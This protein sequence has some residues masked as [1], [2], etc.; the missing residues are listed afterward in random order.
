MLIRTLMVLVCLMPLSIFGQLNSNQIDISNLT[1]EQKILGE[2]YLK[3]SRINHGGV[4]KSNQSNA[5]VT[6]LNS[7]GNDIQSETTTPETLTP[8][9]LL[10]QEYNAIDIYHQV[11]LKENRINTNNNYI[12]LEQF[13]YDF[14]YEYYHRSNDMT[15]PEGYQLQKGD[16][17]TLF[18]F[19]KKEQI[20][21]LT[22]DNEGEVFIPNIGPIVV[23]GLSISEA[24]DKISLKL[25]RKYVNFE[26]RIK[27]NS[28]RNVMILISGNVNQPGTYSVNKFE[29]IFSVLSKANGV[30]KSGSLRNIK[31]LRAN[32]EKSTV[33]LYNYLLNDKLKTIGGFSEGDV[34][35]VPGIGN[36]V[37]IAGA[38][39]K[40]G[41]FEVSDTDS[42]SD[43]LRYASGTGLN[44]YLNTIYINRFDQK[45][46][47]KIKTITGLDRVSAK[48]SNEKVQ[49]GDIIFINKKPNESYGY[50]NILGN[51]NVPG[52][53]EFKKGM[54]L[55]KLISLAEGLK[56]DSSEDVHI[57]R[58]LSENN[59]ELLNISVTNNTFE[60]K[61]RDVVTI[62]N[63]IALKEPEKISIIGEVKEPGQYNYF[64]N[65]SLNDALIIARTK[66]FASLYTIEVS[67]YYG[68][69]SELFYVSKKD[70]KSFILKPRD[71]ISV[72]KDNLRDQTASIELK[73][74][75]IF[76]GIYKV[77]KGSK[78]SD[79]IQRAG[80]YTDSAYLKGAVFLRKD[81]LKYDQTG[82][83]KV[84]EDEKKR[85]I[86]DQSHL[87]NLSVDSK[88][89]MGI[90]M[91]AR[92][93]ALAFLENKSGASS[94][95]VI[96]DLYKNDFQKSK[97]NFTIQDGDTLTIPTKPESVHVIGGVQQGI[98]IAYNPHYGL[99]DY[100]QNVGGFTKYADKG[101]IYIFKSSGKV[102]QNHAKI[103][104]GDIIYVPEKVIISFNWLQF[105]TSITQ[106]VSNAVTSIALV[107]SLQ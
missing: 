73:G 25:R 61:D 104:P 101:N 105:L 23:S 62:Y 98:S 39:N 66:P 91:T 46:K 13:G 7:V 67:R 80:G 84:I 92:Q 37:A 100:I 70:L 103:E 36:T 64:K 76:P 68:K 17:F 28:L 40:P 78:L 87:G 14:F 35:Y 89:S 22:I 51:V 72:K 16:H 18:I 43:V 93:E 48:R 47:R 74:E 52:K 71:R 79:V 69:K 54:T 49:N 2:Q 81:V 34:L 55:G 50:L 107:K 6:H 12:K 102:F 24:K 11:Y 97:D 1:P 26:C 82:Q 99:S 4:Q 90:M 38:V 5:K 65:M 19:G 58:Y 75:F 86:Y 63:K 27:L 96:I 15:I 60:L 31:I 95:R 8:S 9:S 57:F 10:E 3:S 53:F 56:K 29:S 20:L 88:V 77:N 45:F 44:A 30:T 85:F 59:R 41:I 33:D 42:L 32:G 106:I 94:G 21:E 83:K